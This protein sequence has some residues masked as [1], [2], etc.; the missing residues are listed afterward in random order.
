MYLLFKG[1]LFILDNLYLNPLTIIIAVI[2]G[3]STTQVGTL[4][5]DLIDLGAVLKNSI[6]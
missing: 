4:A 3:L 5:L 6:P 1:Y 2:S